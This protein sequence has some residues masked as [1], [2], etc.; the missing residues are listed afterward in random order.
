MI[1]RKLSRSLSNRGV[2]GTVRYGVDCMIAGSRWYLDSWYDLRHRVDTSGKIAIADLGVNSENSTAAT[3]Y[4]PV[5]NSC[6]RQLLSG[7]PISFEQY[8]FID[9]G[10][11]KGRALFLASDYPFRK[12]IGVEFSPELHAIARKNIDSYQS[13]RQRCFQIESICQDAVEFDLPPVPS[14]LFFYSPFNAAILSRV[15][16]HVRESLVQYPRNLY[17]LYVGI[18][19]D[20]IDVLQ[21]AGL[22]CREVPLRRDYLRGETK[23]GFVLHHAAPSP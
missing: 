13:A 2:V 21:T 12:L 15:L 20:L 16:S 22:D 1:P 19:Q 6:I 23:R 4:E 10:S 17:I 8:V 7:L 5:P 14:V 9:F 18:L 3:W 11:G